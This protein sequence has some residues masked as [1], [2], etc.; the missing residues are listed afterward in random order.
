MHA[1]RV[2]AEQPWAKT[3]LGRAAGIDE[4]GNEEDEGLTRGRK[5]RKRVGARARLREQPEARARDDRPKGAREEDDVEV[6][7]HD[8]V[9]GHEL[10]EVELQRGKPVGSKHTQCT[11]VSQ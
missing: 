7:V 3:D 9:E 8:A 1:L 6:D 11:A 5:V 2:C 4:E 10:E